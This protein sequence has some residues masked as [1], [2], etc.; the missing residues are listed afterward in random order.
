MFSVDELQAM[1]DKIDYWDLVA[2]DFRFQ[3][4]GNECKLFIEETNFQNDESCWEILFRHCVKISYKTNAGRGWS[5]MEADGTF[6]KDA[7][8][9]YDVKDEQS[10]LG[11][12][13]Q[14]I[15]I[16]KKLENE[17]LQVDINLS[18]I[19]ITVLCQDIQISKTRISEQHFFW[20]SN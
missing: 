2:L 12:T 6:V 15:T 5:R 13:V 17:L 8:R 9:N 11:Y 20:N 19:S 3:N 7:K 16:Q 18:S 10:L 4:F 1:I 14:D